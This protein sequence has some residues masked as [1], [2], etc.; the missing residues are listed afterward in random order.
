MPQTPLKRTRPSILV[1]HRP[2]PT[3]TRTLGTAKDPVDTR[4]LTIVVAVTITGTSKDSVDMRDKLHR[5]MEETKELSHDT[6]SVLKNLTAIASGGYQ[7]AAS[8]SH[9]LTA[10]CRLWV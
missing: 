3:R 8:R 5:V 10:L 4:E 9:R 6:R 1:A 7:G 2:T